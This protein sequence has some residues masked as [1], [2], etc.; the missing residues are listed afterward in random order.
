MEWYQQHPP[1]ET[2]AVTYSDYLQ[3]LELNLEPSTHEV[4]QV[5]SVNEAIHHALL[6]D[7]ELP[8]NPSAIIQA[9]RRKKM[10]SAGSK[11]R[12]SGKSGNGRAV[13]S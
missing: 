4:Q 6:E 8:E 7:N 9:A 10:A 5:N 11:K 2:V 13:N 12:S 3:Y 1:L